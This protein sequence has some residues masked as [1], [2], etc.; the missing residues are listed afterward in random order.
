MT[1]PPSAFDRLRRALSTRTGDPE[2]PNQA[3]ESDTSAESQPESTAAASVASAANGRATGADGV[4]SADSASS[5][6][7]ASGSSASSPASVS[8]AASP[9][10]AASSARSSLAS[11]Y[12]PETSSTRLE[13]ID[14]ALERWRDE[15][16][17][18][19]GVAAA[20]D[21]TMLDEGVVDLTAAHPSGL[22]QLYAGR[23][24]HLS[25]LVRERSAL[26]AA[27]QSLR[28]VAARTQDLARQFG[29]APVYLAVGVAT[30]TQTGPT[31]GAAQSS[32]ARPSFARSGSDARVETINA[33]VLLRPVRLTGAT[34]D[35]ML[36]LDPSVEVNPLLVKALR[37][38]GCDVDVAA[39]AHAA[40][41]EVGFT[42][43]AALT[44][45]A[46]LGREY[47][48]A[49]DQHERLV[50]GAFV[51]PGQALIEDFDAVRERCRAS[52]LVAALAGDGAACQAL[53]VKLPDP[54]PRDR[55]PEDERGAGDLETQELDAVEA[56]G[57]GASLLLDAPP[58]SDVPTAL[59]AVIADAAGSGRTVLH[60]PASCADGHAVADRLRELGLGELVVDLTEDPAWRRHA[61]E[62]IKEG[63]GVR[64]PQVD[65]EEIVELRERLVT[66]RSRLQRYVGALHAS[67]A[68]WGVS[69]F[70]ALQKL[71]EMTSSR[72]RARTTARIVPGRLEQLDAAGLAR[73]RKVLERAHSLGMLVPRTQ[74]SAWTSLAVTD[75]DEVTDTLAVLRRLSEELLPT[76]SEHVE[77]C[78]RSTG[79]TRAQSLRQWREQLEVLDGV[80]ESL[81]IFRPQIF[82]RSAADM[83]I[84]TATRQWREEHDVEMNAN[85]RRRFQRQAREWVRPGRVV[86]DLHA[87]LVQ[88]QRR[89]E[90][91]RRYTP[92]G[93]WP[94]LPSSLD[95]M[96]ATAKETLSQL[97]QVQVL[98]DR[99]PGTP[100]LIDLTLD[101][102]REQV[103]TLAA[104]DNEAVRVPEL[105]KVMAD[106]AELG[107]GPLVDD[108][109]ARS[110]QADQLELELTY[111]WWSS[112]L[113]Q[114]L[115][116]DPDMGGLDAAALAA[117]A[118]SLRELDAA[119][120]ESLSVPVAQAHARRVRSQVDEHLEQ[121]RALFTNLAREEGADLSEVIER[122]PLALVAK[123]VWIVP[124]MLVPQVFSANALLDLAVLDA[125]VSIPVAQVLPA[126]VRAEQV[127]VVGDPRRAESGLAAELGPLLPKVTLPTTRHAF[128]PM[129]AAFLAAND[130]QG[131]IEAVPTP[132]G[133]QSLSLELVDGRGAAA[134]GEVAVETV[135]AEVNRVVD[136]VIEHVLSTPELSLAVIALNT[137][138]ADA[139][140]QAIMQ[141]LS[142]S[143]A[144][145]RFFSD[146]GAEPFVVVDLNECRSLRRD[147]IILSVGYA[148]T[149]HGRTIHRFGRVAQKGG[150]VALVEAL[151]AAR[152]RTLV[153]SCLRAVDLDP[154]RLT[155]AGSRLLR[156][157][158]EQAE[159]G[160]DD[161]TADGVAPDPLLVDLAE[162]LWRRGLT[163]RPR[164][165]LE[166]GA[167]IPLAIGH[168]DFPGELFVA[169]LTDNAA[170]VAEPS[171]RRRDRHWVERL[172]RRGWLVHM[173][174][175]AGVFVDPEAE[176]RRVEQLVESVIRARRA[177][178]PPPQ[179]AIPQE[180]ADMVPV[181]PVEDVAEAVE[182]EPVHSEASA[183][184]ADAPET[185]SST[186]SAPSDTT[187][188]A[189]PA[190]PQRVKRPP[191]AAGLPLQAY[192]DDQLDD[193]V[194]WIRSDGVA[195]DESEEIEELRATLA[196]RRRGASVDAVLSNAVRR[197][198]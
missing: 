184:T 192:S 91:W 52:A 66:V 159:G 88:V 13:R 57:S 161:D 9:S 74:P 172:E 122:Y 56:V 49:F 151:C 29:V 137:R 111:C 79:M 197:G 171:L 14:T 158:L 85:T 8:S 105:N 187:A 19:G 143:P 48:P 124:P 41:S 167:R 42:P 181:E 177:P 92:E 95:E 93:G 154:S 87:E 22:A 61:A 58:G 99:T 125:S 140:R 168:P 131:T 47:L 77:K 51:H 176:A 78:S 160:V 127:L 35:A 108:L 135:A 20:S 130:Y 54:E 101:D 198:R 145:E 53:D 126:F 59:A 98:L 86:G 7:G 128:D 180:V 12:E 68:P 64:P 179:A 190:E 84:A 82:E 152:E 138:H 81:D 65:T 139:I 31:E 4:A 163:V 169:V 39:I 141:E 38:H 71:A 194:A 134:P 96:A 97:D 136:L 80:R 178:A 5:A 76:V 17:D 15:L 175:S 153:V 195:R 174:F 142:G 147:R 117:L 133:A 103:G 1:P 45:L 102:L 162:H 120:S 11:A 182:T 10:S 107:L 146:H 55:F 183:S 16:L 44:R 25:S 100:K 30:W 6:S 62:A 23:A 106:I 83:V 121:A 3:T 129:I 118:K 148:K 193:L 186:A 185:A 40:V 109:A 46:S 43:R 164:Y 60:V 144:L 196:L 119:Q 28:E 115:R 165:G 173:A 32:S 188:E 116:D 166:G 156:E 114:A 24:T 89:R 155:A 157:L 63:L 150:M 110:A 113:A 149:V 26:L 112:V 94:S 34:G 33:P 189:A 191:I 170:Y 75:L 21:I 27:R 104:Q 50:V 132:P 72:T 2:A 90:I 70:E 18:L 73:A 123:P 37:A 67:R 69:A 36:A